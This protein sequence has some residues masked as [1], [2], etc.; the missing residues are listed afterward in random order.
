MDMALCEVPHRACATDPIG[1]GGTAR[2]QRWKPLTSDTELAD[3]T[4]REPLR[5]QWKRI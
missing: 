1:F 5:H 4:A 3:R 2:A